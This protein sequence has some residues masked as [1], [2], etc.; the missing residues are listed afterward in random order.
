MED[1]GIQTRGGMEDKGILTDRAVQGLTY[2]TS[3]HPRPCCRRFIPQAKAVVN[4]DHWAGLTP[5]N[6]PSSLFTLALSIH[7][8]KA[9]VNVGHWAGLTPDNAAD[10]EALSELLAAGALGFKVGRFNS[11][12]GSWLGHHC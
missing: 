11:W 3:P 1:K 8:A 2:L 10:H 4:V 9:I 6:A 12:R 5:V 7:Q